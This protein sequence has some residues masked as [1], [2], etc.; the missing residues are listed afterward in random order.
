MLSV[1]TVELDTQL[2]VSK[3]FIGCRLY[4][5]FDVIVSNFSNATSYEICKLQSKQN[6]WALEHAHEPL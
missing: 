3:I 6:A 1:N 5:N 2:N 4:S